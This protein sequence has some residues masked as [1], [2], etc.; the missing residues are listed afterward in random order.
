MALT[1]IY[2]QKGA[3]KSGSGSSGWKVKL[4]R[5][6]TTESTELAIHDDKLPYRSTN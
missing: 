5:T 2:S 1:F 4:F 6:A 3:S